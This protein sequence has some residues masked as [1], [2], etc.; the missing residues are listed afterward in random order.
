[1]LIK[2]HSE[3][4]TLG[5]L[6]NTGYKSR[7]IKDEMRENL[8][9]QLQN[10]ENSF[11]GIVGYE[12]SVIPD[13]DTSILSRHNILLLGLRGQAKTRLARLMINLLDE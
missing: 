13:I 4:R 2:N 5:Q 8:I 1:M 9:R 3:I 12:Q 10:N 11:H 6:K 7:S